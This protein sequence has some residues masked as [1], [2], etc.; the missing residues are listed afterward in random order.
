MDSEVDVTQL[1]L[2][3]S[4]WHDDDRVQSRVCLI[5]SLA[6]VHQVNVH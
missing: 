5:D 2:L 4:T 3:P 1:H 6:L